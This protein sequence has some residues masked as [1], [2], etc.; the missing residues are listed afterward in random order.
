MGGEFD[1]LTFDM[2]HQPLPDGFTK[3]IHQFL[4]YPPHD[5]LVG[6]VPDGDFK[7][8]VE[9]FMERVIRVAILLLQLFFVEKMFYRVAGKEIQISS[10]R[11]IIALDGQILQII[12]RFE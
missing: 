7:I 4:G 10:N 1:I 12:Y 2:S 11:T 9:P 3:V 8:L 5:H 6:Q